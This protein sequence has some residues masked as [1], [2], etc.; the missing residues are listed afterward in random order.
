MFVLGGFSLGLGCVE[1]YGCVAECLA[2]VCR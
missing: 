1:M 2:V